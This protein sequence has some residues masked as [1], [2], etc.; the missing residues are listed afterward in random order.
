MTIYRQQ[1][2]AKYC[3]YVFGPTHRVSFKTHQNT[4]SAVLW[5]RKTPTLTIAMPVAPQRDALVFIKS[6]DLRKEPSNV[7]YAHCDSFIAFPMNRSPSALKRKLEIA[8]I[9]RLSALRAITKNNIRDACCWWSC[10]EK[11]TNEPTGTHTSK[12]TKKKKSKQ[13]NK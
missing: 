6:R 5:N 7:P 4:A 9:L 11:R 10:Y 1:M 13:R 12:H 3:N 8:V 2:T